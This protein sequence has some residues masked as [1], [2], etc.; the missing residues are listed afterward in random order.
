MENEEW[1]C[2]S[3]INYPPSSFGGKPCCF[4][5]PGDPIL[6]AYQKKEERI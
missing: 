2:L 6:N 5:E 3:C 1:I 4:C